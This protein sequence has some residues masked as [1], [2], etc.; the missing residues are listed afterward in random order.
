MVSRAVNQYEFYDFT[1]L[2]VESN[3]SPELLQQHGKILFEENFVDILDLDQF[4]TT[5]RNFKLEAIRGHRPSRITAT[6]SFQDF[7]ESMIEPAGWEA[8]IN[9]QCTRYNLINDSDPKQ[10]GW[11]YLDPDHEGDRVSIKHLF[12]GESMKSGAGKYEI[13]HA[14]V[15]L[16][17]SL[18]LNKS[19]LPHNFTFNMDKKLSDLPRKATAE[20]CKLRTSLQ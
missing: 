8:L 17:Y 19:K 16:L 7:R 13:I 6:Y 11:I 12:S 5:N 3:R 15:A 9:I 14:W 18:E 2:L 10:D 20:I 1:S 4:K